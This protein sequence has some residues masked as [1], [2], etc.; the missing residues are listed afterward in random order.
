MN[1]D[2]TRQSRSSRALRL[3]F[4][5]ALTV[6]SLPRAAAAQDKNDDE[7][8]VQKL[9]ADPKA[10]ADALKHCQP[11]AVAEDR[12]CHAAQVARNRQ[13]FGT[14]TVPYTPQPVDPFPTNPT[15]TPNPRK[16]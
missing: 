14:G 5:L 11:D 8:L 10:L 2:R 15:P 9:M 7:A 1:P 6:I 12:E 3:A 4:A 16:P 13:F